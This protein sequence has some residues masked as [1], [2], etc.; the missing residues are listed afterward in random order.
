M[1]ASM[2]DQMVGLAWMLA[3]ATVEMRVVWMVALLGLSARM[4]VDQMVGYLVDPKVGS[5]AD[6]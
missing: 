4:W 2:V 5:M 6:Y 1:A 3:V